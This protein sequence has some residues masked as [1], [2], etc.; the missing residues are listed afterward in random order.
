MA[1]QTLRTFGWI[2]RQVLPKRW[3]NLLEQAHQSTG[4]QVI[5]WPRPEP[6]GISHAKTVPISRFGRTG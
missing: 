6:I 3:V 4:N 5:S 1:R 2:K